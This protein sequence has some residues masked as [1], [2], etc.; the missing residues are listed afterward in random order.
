FVGAQRLLFAFHGPMTHSAR[1][2][3]SPCSQSSVFQV[4]KYTP[5]SSR[6][7]LLTD[8]LTDT[9]IRILCSGSCRPCCLR[10]T[11]QS[12]SLLTWRKKSLSAIRRLLR[13]RN[14]R[15]E[16]SHE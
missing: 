2:C 9:P 11:R 13:S 12:P 3:W 6:P 16:Q 1:L 14:M 10:L 8:T 4:N 5:S 7:G 15:L